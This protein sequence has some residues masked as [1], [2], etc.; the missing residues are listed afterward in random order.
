MS[1]LQSELTIIRKMLTALLKDQ[2]GEG[3]DRLHTIGG[4]VYGRTKSGD[5]YILLYPARE[6]LVKKVCRVYPQDF[7]KLPSFI[8]TKDTPNDTKENPDK[9]DAIRYGIFHECPMFGIVT[10]AG[11][12]TQMG[13]EV[14]FSDVLWVSN[15][16]AD[17]APTPPQAPPATKAP[18]QTSA[19]SPGAAPVEEA[20]P[21]PIS[22]DEATRLHALGA[23][24]LGIQ[25]WA[26]KVSGAAQWVSGGAVDHIEDLAPGE[27]GKLEEWLLSLGEKRS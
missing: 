2:S 6:D 24:K 16:L 11:K 22:A 19:T 15:K 1:D 7:R 10:Y 13:P 21:S 4:Y 8:N 14:R 17:G 9:P 18:S 5:P 26:S 12:E 23:E 20:P 27:A 25:R 3:K